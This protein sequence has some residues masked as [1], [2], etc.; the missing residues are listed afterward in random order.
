MSKKKISPI[1]QPPSKDPVKK[2]WRCHFH[3]FLFVISLYCF[4]CLRRNLSTCSMFSSFQCQW[5][6]LSDL[7]TILN[8][9]TSIIITIWVQWRTCY[10]VHYTPSTCSIFS[11]FQ[12]QCKILSDLTTIFNKIASNIIT[13]WVQWVTCYVVPFTLSNEY[14]YFVFFFPVTMKNSV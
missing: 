9:I 12:F 8:K 4:Q 2:S 14:M 13:I 11:S 1:H 7:A 3:T 6:S 5:R 10:V